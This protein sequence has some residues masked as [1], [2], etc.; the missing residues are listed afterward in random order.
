[1]SL[2]C[3]DVSLGPD[4]LA[5]SAESENSRGRPDVT[6]RAAFTRHAVV[7]AIAMEVALKRDISISTA[8]FETTR[9]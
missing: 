7:R 9:P 1:M 4:D 3:S 6:G 2:E 5:E 8:M